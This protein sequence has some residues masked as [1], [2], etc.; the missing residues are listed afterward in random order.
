MSFDDRPP[1]AL[2]RQNLGL[3]GEEVAVPDYDRGALRPGVVHIGVGGFHRSHQAMYFDEL[4]RNGVTDWAISGIN[5]RRA[6]IVDALAPQ[7]FL[8]TLVERCAA[9][10]SARV[11]GSLTGGCFAP[12]APQAAL[13]ALADPAVRLVTL[14]ITGDGYEAEPSEGSFAMGAFDLLGAALAR[15]RLVGTPPFTV[16]SCDNLPRNGEAAREATLAAVGRSSPSFADWV[17]EHVRFPNSVVDRITPEQTPLTREYVARRFGVEDRAPV[18]AEPFAQWVIEDAFCNERPP[19]DLVGARFVTDVEEYA[20]VKKRMLNGGHSALGYVGYLLGHRSTDEA[21]ADP[22]VE[23]YVDRLLAAEVAP[24]LPSPAGME[25]DEYRR[26][27]LERFA[28]PKLGDQLSRLCGRGSTKVPSYLLPSVADAVRRRRPHRLLALGVAAW[29][30]Y[31][32]GVDLDNDP[33]PIH[34][35][36][37]DELQ[38]VAVAG[39]DDPCFL[40]R[41]RGL[42]GELSNASPFAESLEDALV[43]I[44]RDGLRATLEEHVSGDLGALSS[45]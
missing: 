38:P 27:L 6:A 5:L 32:R 22:L 20:L 26:S 29:I 16:L 41:N 7:D 44:D 23:R 4:A 18:V 10:E 45:R 31:L 12:H 36:Q 14:T 24:L 17:G 43:A 37:L 28:N 1:I 19:L 25:L 9:S 35:A 8:Y 30:R 33:I 40:L 21:M 13:A 34:D 2:C 3:L 39:R 15:R 42:F 11:I